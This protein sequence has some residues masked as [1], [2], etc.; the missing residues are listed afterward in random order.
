[1]TLFNKASQL[2]WS[3]YEALS[4]VVTAVGILCIA[5][6]AIKWIIAGD[7]A[8]VKSAKSWLFSILAGLTVFHMAELIVN[9]VTSLT[10]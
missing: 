1:M 9:T 4:G 2:L 10:V 3:I 7:P 8:S 5:I 6:C